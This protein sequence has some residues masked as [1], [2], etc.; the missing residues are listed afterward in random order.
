MD[1]KK[2]VSV[3]IEISREYMSVV[4][5]ESGDREVTLKRCGSVENPSLL[6]NPSLSAGNI[7]DEE[8]FKALIKNLLDSSSINS[9]PLIETFKG[10]HISVAIPDACV[11]TAFLEFEDIPAE[12]ERVIAMIKWN[13]KKT[14]PFSVDET[15]VDFQ[16]ID[17]PSVEN[18][19]YRLVVVLARKT[20]LD[21]YERLL[22]EC[23]LYPNS[24]IPSSLAVYNLYHDTIAK[25]DLCALLSVSTDRI[26][27]LIVKNGKPCF[28]RSKEIGD[29]N[30][31]LR[32]ILASLNYYQDVYRAMP[33]EI[34][35]VNLRLGL[36]DLKADLERQLGNISLKL[37][38]MADM[39]KGVN[40]SMNIFSG[41]AGAALKA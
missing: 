26:A 17:T 10:R 24:I 12:R 16:L 30:E 37:L 20:V 3:G 41:A 38:N 28:Y 2:G 5:L 25:P 15:V 18:R 35:L 29:E 1:L 7:A 21:Q 8:K 14:I 9:K 36:A 27:V 6:V 11:K 19:L 34:Y 31:G 39:V 13:L 4:E 33:A 32:E 23:R 40:A 22:K